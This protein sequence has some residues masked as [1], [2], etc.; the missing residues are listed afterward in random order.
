MAGKGSVAVP[1]QDG[2]ATLSDV[3]AGSGQI[4]FAVSVEVGSDHGSRTPSPPYRTAG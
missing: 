1:K 2:H 4:Y 3:I